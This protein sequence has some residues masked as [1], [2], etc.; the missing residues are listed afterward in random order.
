MAAAVSPTIDLRRAALADL[1]AIDFRDPSRDLAADEAAVHDRLLAS[2]AGLDDA[3]WHLPGA[4]PSDAGG[5][6]W[7]L[8]EH[9]GHVVDWQELAIDYIAVAVETGRW[10]TDDDFDGGDFDRYNEARRMPW[11]TMPM[12]VMLERSTIARQRLLT[13]VAG[14]PPADIRSDAAW[15]WIHFVLHGHYLDHLVVLEPWTAALRV[16]QVDG[17]PF[18][19]D[20]R[21]ADHAAFRAEDAAIAAQ[22]DA[23]VRPVPV[24]RWTLDELTPGWTL[25]DHVAHLAD[26]A[27]EGVR[28]IEVYRRRGHWLADPDEGIDAWNERHVAASRA[29]GESPAAT[30]ARY[31]RARAD[32]LDAIDT[33]SVDELRSP[34]G[35][36]WA[37]DCLYGHDRKHLAMVGR[38]CASVGWPGGAIR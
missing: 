16:R 27:A 22:V 13:A 29:A 14:L 21:V 7:S 37:Y 3:A 15:G 31:D 11:T 24:E 4:A 2:W 33:L 26:W 10:P 23:L 32:L 36:A 30:L 12:V 34:D 35:W 9:V 28:A 17:D 8:A 38:W 25:R 1:R 5:P 20:P 6:D 18:L 19:P